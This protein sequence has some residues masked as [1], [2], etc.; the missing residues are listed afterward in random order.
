MGS[1]AVHLA[2][3]ATHDISN[4][5]VKLFGFGWLAQHVDDV[6]RITFAPLAFALEPSESGDQI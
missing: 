4:S 3:D 6:S 1:R 5:K 2:Y